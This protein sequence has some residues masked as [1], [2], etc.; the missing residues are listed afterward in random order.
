VFAGTDNGL[1]RFNS[2]TTNWSQANSGLTDLY[3]LSLGVAPNGTT[4]LAGTANGLF[5]STNQGQNWA[6]VASGISEKVVAFVF[7]Q[8]GTKLLAGTVSGIYLSDDNGASWIVYN[9]GLL[10]PQV[11]ALAVKDKL[12]VAGT[13]GSGVF[14]GQIPDVLTNHPPTLNLSCPA[15]QTVAIGT[16]INCTITASD[17]ELNQ[18]LAL[19]AGGLPAGATFNP[20]TG[21]FAWTPSAVQTGIQTIAFTATDNGSPRLA[22]SRELTIT[23]NN[24]TPVLS[25]LL[26]SSIGAGG[27]DLNLNVI[28]SGFVANSIVRWNGNGRPTNYTSPTQLSATIPATDIAS[29]GTA[30]ISVFNTTPGGGTSNSLTFT[31]GSPCSFGITPPGQQFS[32]ASGTGTVNITATAGCAWTAVSNTTS[33]ITITAGASGTGNGTVSYS[34]SANTSATGRQGT[35]TIAGQTFTVM[36]A[37]QQAGSTSLRSMTEPSSRLWAPTQLVTQASSIDSHPR[38]TR[39]SPRKSRSFFPR[40]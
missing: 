4:L 2:A 3:V 16:P 24:P 8:G 12:V 29:P 40:R 9:T 1:F 32:A 23:V 31:I 10:N 39:L 37:G 17:P 20:N 35:M 19:T 21:A 18:S 27:A 28:G 22:S 11:S 14:V 30:A 15:S 13:R 26:P 7:T 33:F 25:S 6:K 34:V 5:R 38:A 36:Q